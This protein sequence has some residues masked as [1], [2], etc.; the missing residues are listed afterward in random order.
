MKVRVPK[1]LYHGTVTGGIKEFEPRKRYTP[2]I[3]D[4]V[5]RIY[6]TDKPVFAVMHAF[7]WSS[8]DGVDIVTRDENLCLQVPVHL[9]DRLNQSI[10]IYKLKGDTFVLTEE[11]ATGNTYHSEVAVIPESVESFNSVFEALEYFGG[12][13][14]FMQ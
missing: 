14:D 12:N 8:D 10:F 4:S 5:P 9:K 1:F 2:G 7:P 11:E 3:G 6:A 13:V